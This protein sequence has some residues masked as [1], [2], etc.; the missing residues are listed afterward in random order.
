VDQESLENVLAERTEIPIQRRQE[1]PADS[2]PGER[3]SR[4]R[5]RRLSLTG[6]VLGIAAAWLSV[7]PSL[8]PRAWLIQVLLTGLCLLSVYAI[9]AA[10]GW[11]YRSLHVPALPSTV[12][13]VAW[14]VI[15]VVAPIGL[16]VAGW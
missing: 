13:R 14:R 5:L 6:A 10:L 15:A 12:R 9:G 4:S 11:G 7:T 16:I 8:V 2:A 1:G 3:A